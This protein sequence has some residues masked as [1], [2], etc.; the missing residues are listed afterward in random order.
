MSSLDWL[1]GIVEGEGSISVTGP[2]GYRR[3]PQ[4]AVEMT[5]RDVIQRVA[6]LFDSTITERQRPGFKTLYVTRATCRKGAYWMLLLYSLLGHRRRAR[7]REVLRVY[8]ESFK[9]RPPRYK[10]VQETV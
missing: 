10:V 2:R 8:G 7:I 6:S 9:N 5:D 4:L 1:A 3:Y